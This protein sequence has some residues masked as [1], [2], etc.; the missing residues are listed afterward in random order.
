MYS[1][2]QSP[3]ASQ[4]HK[5]HKMAKV[6]LALIVTLAKLIG[7]AQPQSNWSFCQ[8]S[9]NLG[10]TVSVFMMGILRAGA[11]IGLQTPAVSQVLQ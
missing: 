5:T 1:K 3:A 4:S 8:K 10:T 6:I 9:I 7:S 2:D 11:T